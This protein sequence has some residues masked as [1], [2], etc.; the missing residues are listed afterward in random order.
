MFQNKVINEHFPLVIWHRYG[1]L[2][3]YK[4]FTLQKS[5]FSSYV[6]LPKGSK[7][8]ILVWVV[9]TTNQSVAIAMLQQGTASA[10]AWVKMLPR[11]R[12]CKTCP[13]RR[14]R[15]GLSLN[16]R[17]NLFNYLTLG[18]IGS[19]LPSNGLFY[20]TAFCSNS[21]PLNSLNI[22]RFWRNPHLSH[23][24]T[25]MYQT[26]SQ[27]LQLLFAMTRRSQS[28]PAFPELRTAMFQLILVTFR[29]FVSFAVPQLFGK[30]NG[31][32]LV[33]SHHYSHCLASY[34][35]LGCFF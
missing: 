35:R 2:P 16:R 28:L 8:Y 20:Q 14:I 7:K 25:L 27:T 32:T 10:T 29:I 1:K 30:Q 23:D 15:M 24:S 31:V 21:Y 17:C 9:E 3:I 13:E 26:V 12:W 34:F 6:N 22:P 18:Y 33:T 5:W 4:G 19:V 11:F